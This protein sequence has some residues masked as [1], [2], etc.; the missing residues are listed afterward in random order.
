MYLDSAMGVGLNV[1]SNGVTT[2]NSA[3]GVTLAP[4]A[5]CKFAI[6]WS[7]ARIAYSINGAAVVAITGAALPLSLG[8]FSTTADG[9]WFGTITT[10]TVYSQALSDA[11]LRA[12]TA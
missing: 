5:Q 4:N 7:P 10:P 8:T 9:Q 12:L 2:A 1:K 3:G 11:T 6:S